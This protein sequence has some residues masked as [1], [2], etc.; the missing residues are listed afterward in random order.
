MR[1]K[2]Q[3][4]GVGLS[5]IAMAL[6]VQATELYDMNT[7]DVKGVSLGMNA[8]EAIKILVDRYSI[9]E[10]DINYRYEHGT[11]VRNIKMRMSYNAEDV[12]IEMWFQPDLAAKQAGYTT[13][14]SVQVQDKSTTRKDQLNDMVAKFGP[15]SVS[16]GDNPE[17][18][19][20][21]WCAK[22]NKDKNRCVYESGQLSFTIHG[23]D[24]VGNEDESWDVLRAARGMMKELG[25]P[26]W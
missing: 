26:G 14:E 12:Y 7:L 4:L 20:Y 8:D 19:S 17:S 3:L 22:L 18:A 23:A 1:I 24:L 2:S 9:N 21:S 11:T 13:V 16:T 25:V 5:L 15:P 10:D 6:P